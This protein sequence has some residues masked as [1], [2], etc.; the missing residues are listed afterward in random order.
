MQ[1]IHDAFEDVISTE[2]YIPEV[3]AVGSLD[4]VEHVLYDFALDDPLQAVA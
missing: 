2:E 3:C 1:V 4:P